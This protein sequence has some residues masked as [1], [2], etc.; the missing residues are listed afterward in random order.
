MVSLN[1][2]EREAEVLRDVLEQQ[3]QTLL[4]EIAKTDTREY[5]DTLQERETIMRGISDQLEEPRSR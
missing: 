4:L 2:S 3:H 1:L 5:R